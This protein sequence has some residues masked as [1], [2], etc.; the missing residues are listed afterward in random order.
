MT[1]KDQSII[2][3]NKIIYIMSNEKKIKLSFDIEQIANDVLVKCNQISKSIRDDAMEDIKADVLEPD[4][5]ESRSIINRSLTEAFGE[6]KVM[7]Q[8]YLKAGRTVD[9]NVLERMVKSVTYVQVQDTDS[10]GR[11]L[12]IAKVSGADVVVYQ[13]D[14]VTPAVWK[15]IANDTTVI[16]DTGTTP[17]PKMVDSD[18]IDTMEYETVNFY[19]YIPNFNVAVT[20]HLKSGIHKYIV[21][22]IMSRF[23]QDQLKDKADEYKTLADGEDHVQII[24]DLNARD[25]FTFR[26]PSWV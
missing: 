18:E 12:Y 11:L 15:N 22:Y 16:P 17:Q 26:K 6:V 9:N 19:L 4:N 21:D 2:S 1:P 5:P 14:S 25:R 3:T 24:R 10:Q 20:D 13:D 23:L 8:R 7:C